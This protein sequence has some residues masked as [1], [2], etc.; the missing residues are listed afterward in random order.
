M[1]TP[2]LTSAEAKAL[3]DGALDTFAEALPNLVVDYLDIVRASEDAET[4][5]RAIELAAKL[6]GIAAEKQSQVYLPTVNITF[7]AGMHLTATR[8]Q[9]EVIDITPD[10]VELEELCEPAPDPLAFI[11]LLPK[12]A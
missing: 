8:A 11:K 3:T 10:L 5:R 7:G 12:K 9:S 6:R 2:K 4:M 1:T